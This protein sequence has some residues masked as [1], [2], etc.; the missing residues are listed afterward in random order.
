[1]SEIGDMIRKLAD[2]EIK[3]PEVCKVVY[4]D[5]AD[6]EYTINA[7]RLSDIEYR[8]DAKQQD[9]DD[10]TITDIRLNINKEGNYVVPAKD[11]YIMVMWDERDYPYCLMIND[12]ERSVTR[13]IT[14]IISVTK[15]T[16]YTESASVNIVGTT[17]ITIDGK[18]IELNGNNYGG[19]IMIDAL[20]EKINRLETFMNSHIHT[21]AAAGSPT[22]PV[23]SP[24]VPSTTKLDLENP[25]I[26][27]GNDEPTSMTQ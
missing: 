14:E 26:K 1:M 19:M 18:V 3:L 16:N 21:S 25:T 17:D 10:R 11:S 27:H 22:S 4:I 24:L 9:I 12:I 6:T 8:N 23:V 2:I 5:D 7:V 13:N 20:V 15:E